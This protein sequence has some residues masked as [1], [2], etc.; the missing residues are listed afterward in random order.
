MRFPSGF[1]FGAATA[2]YQIEGAVDEDGRRP[3]I[4]DTFATVPGAV[5]HGDT[6][7]I[8]CDH[9][10]RLD[11][12]LDLAAELGLSAY[13]FSV[14][15][16]R[17]IPDGYGTVN[18]KGLDFYRRLIDG[19][20][21]R[22]IQ[23]AATLYH[24]DLPQP[25]QD[26]GG[27]A[28]RDTV[29]HFCDYAEVVLESL[30]DAVP[31]WGTVN[32]PFCA[33]MI[34]YLQGRHAPGIADLRSALRASHHLLLAHGHAVGIVRR[35]APDARVG[36]SHL[37]SDITPASQSPA[38][39][40]AAARLDGYENR[41]FLDPVLRGEYP[42]DMLDWY[43]RQ[44]PVDFIRDGDLAVVAAPA[45][46]LGVNY[47]ETKTVV[48]DPGEPYHQAREL[49]A[50]GRRTAGGLDVR[51]AALGRILRRVSAATTLP[52]YITENGAAF[53]DYVDPEGGVD[54]TERV[55]YLADHFDETL[56]AIGAGA[57]VRGFFV[58]SLL[59]NF[60]W[61]DGYSRRFG[62]VY[63]DFGTQSRIP[64]ASARWYQRLI[65][66]NQDVQG[67]PPAS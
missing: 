29:G 4:W 61:A 21:A 54:D 53:H 48:H 8:A 67:P 57:D 58:W 24:W 63:V 17:V 12:D 65:A 41:W 66:R 45:D 19:L 16:P 37:L 27:W 40:A 46:F 30:G 31:L 64:K 62:L 26:A 20:H 7:A 50:A 32:E 59:D 5:T 56:A 18:Q 15:W 1:L 23:P 14:A 28:N 42:P 55:S 6:G 36:I 38:D 44:V 9:Y 51:P 47:Y 3:S 25:L 33:G 34:G 13:R 10:H 52:L 22:N 2:A 35:R 11:T 39:R 49:P 43:A 60:E